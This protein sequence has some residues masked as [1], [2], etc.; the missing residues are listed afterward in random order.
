MLDLLSLL[1]A[2]IQLAVKLSEGYKYRSSDII[3]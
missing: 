2:G 1:G 3:L